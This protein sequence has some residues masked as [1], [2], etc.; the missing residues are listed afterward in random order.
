VFIWYSSPQRKQKQLSS[1]SSCGYPNPDCVFLLTDIYYICSLAGCNR[2]FGTVSDY[3][4]LTL[5]AARLYQGLAALYDAKEGKVVGHEKYW[6]E[7]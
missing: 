7:F 5:R 1:L 6:R 4:S 3:L 2:N